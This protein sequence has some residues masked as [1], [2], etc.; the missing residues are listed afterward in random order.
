MRGPLCNVC[1]VV[2]A[3]KSTKSSGPRKI[4]TPEMTGNSKPQ[5][6]QLSKP[7]RMCCSEPSITFKTPMFARQKGHRSC[8]RIFVAIHTV[9]PQDAAVCDQQ[10]ARPPRRVA[11]P[12]A[13]LAARCREGSGCR[14]KNSASRGSRLRRSLSLPSSGRALAA[15]VAVRIWDSGSRSANSSPARL[16][17]A[18]SRAAILPRLEALPGSSHLLRYGIADTSRSAFT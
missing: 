9:N 6:G 3:L 18:G 2:S 5:S 4:A 7:C 13:S 11:R 14:L 15:R 16:S 8:S 12:A 10:A 17:R 1:A